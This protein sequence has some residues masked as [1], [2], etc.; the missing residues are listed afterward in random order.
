MLADTKPA[1]IQNYNGCQPELENTIR[2]V[3][4][5]WMGGEKRQIHTIPKVFLR[6]RTKLSSLKFEFDTFYFVF[7]FST[8]VK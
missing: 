1:R 6:K 8:H 4:T 7:Y 2:S 3:F 5:P